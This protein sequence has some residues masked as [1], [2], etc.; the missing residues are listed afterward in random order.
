MQ[1]E[2]AFPEVEGGLIS[3]RTARWRKSEVWTMAGAAVR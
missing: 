3:N 2:G 1:G